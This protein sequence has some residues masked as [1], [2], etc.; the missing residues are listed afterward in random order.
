MKN[1]REKRDKERELT[2]RCE[3]IGMRKNFH[4]M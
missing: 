1:E 3:R 4:S 2:V